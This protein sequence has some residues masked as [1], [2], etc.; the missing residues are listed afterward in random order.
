M[1]GFW[2]GQSIRALGAAMLLGAAAC[3]A[4]GQEG[5]RTPP[6][7]DPK[8]ASPMPVRWNAGL[9]VSPTGAVTIAG[10]A[11]FSSST[12]AVGWEP[13]GV[14]VDHYE[15]QA[16]DGVA[17]TSQTVS[18]ASP[19]LLLMGLKAGTAYTVTVKAC[20]DRG[21]S[22]FLQSP[23]TTAAT[24]EE[25]WQVQGAGS[26]YATAT[27]V[28]ADGNVGAHGFRFGAWAR[29][30]LRGRLQLYYNPLSGSEKGV[31]TAVTSGPATD[32]ASV[33]RF[34]GIGGF[35]LRTPCPATPPG[36]PP[37]NCPGTGLVRNVS[38][39]QAVPMNGFVRLYFEANGTDQRSR[40]LYLDSQDGEIGRDFH[41]GAETLCQTMADYAAGGA[42]EPA[43]AIGVQGDAVAGNEGV[44]HARQFKIL[45]P[46]REDGRW[47]GAP[48][49]AMIFTVNPANPGCSPYSFTQAYAV[50]SGSR[51]QVQYQPNGCPK[52]FE[53]MQAPNPVHLGGARYKLYFNNNPILRGQS[54]DPLSNLKPMKL[55]YADGARTGDPA[56]V[57]FEDWEP[58]GAARELH[59][60]W[61]DGTLLDLDS[62]SKF[63]DHV[64]ILPTGDPGFQVIY[65]NMSGGQNSQAPPFVGMAV[66]L[67][68]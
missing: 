1:N 44:Q 26:G 41:R 57:D 36:Q 19:G 62:E 37:P 64:T 9:T 28:V 54:N 61:P 25:Y 63:D 48:G 21:C 60:L 29:P 31:K 59:Y 56:V 10:R 68:P 30:E 55:L 38:L 49:T 2:S 18:A 27:R 14:P 16:V 35:G 8:P 5:P 13:P 32:L 17:A 66:L 43:V 12:L 20:L 24:S 4:R 52:L 67:N 15:A 46:A 6:R 7:P 11:I 50:W 40:I 3:A 22:Q 47:D 33:S 39:F 58:A 23:P 42:C 34:Q 45:Y 51:W 65:A 53:Q